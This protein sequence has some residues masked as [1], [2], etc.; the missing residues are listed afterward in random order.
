MYKEPKPASNNWIAQEVHRNYKCARCTHCSHTHNTKVFSHPQ[1]G[2]KYKIKEFIN[3]MSTHVVYMLKC[4]CGMIYIG[5]T[6]RNLK[7]R[8]AKHKA[9]IRN[10]NMDYTIARHYR[11][12]N[13]GSGASFKF[14][15]IERILPNPRGG[16]LVQKLLKREAYWIYTLNSMEPHGLNE[17][18]GLRSYL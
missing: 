8:I 2:E 17:S 9:A 1:T 7:L 14:I 6:K 4:P 16:N 3:C 12:R 11:D 18:S 13:H 5:Q 10:G 15:G